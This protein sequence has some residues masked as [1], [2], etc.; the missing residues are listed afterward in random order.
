MPD[1]TTTALLTSIRRR[2]GAPNAT[3]QGTTDADILAMAT[4]ELNG[5]VLSLLKQINEGHLVTTYET[6]IVAGQAAYAIPTRALGAAVRDVVL[7]RADGTTKSLREMDYAELPDKQGMSGEPVYF[8]FKDA[9]VCLHPAPSASGGYLQLPY[10]RSCSKLVTT[11]DCTSVVSIAGNVITCSGDALPVG[12]VEGAKLDLVKA[13]SPFNI[14]SMDLTI[15]GI[16]GLNV[17]VNSAPPST[18]VTGTYVCLAEESPV[19]QIPK[20]M[21]PFLAQ[22]TAVELLAG[23]F[24]DLEQLGSALGKMQRLRVEV[25]PF[26]MSPRNPGEQYPLVNPYFFGGWDV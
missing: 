9:D 5:E 3:S 19:P 16:A 23:P 2:A 22:A 7:K 18:A 25:L 26:L 24:G 21:F 11:A 8:Y 13:T 4:D 12:F 6:A 14:L 15:T 17:T 10:Y 1:Y 20:E